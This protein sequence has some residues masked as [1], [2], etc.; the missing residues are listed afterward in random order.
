M[1]GLVRE[2][3]EE[4][5]EEE[6]SGW[7]G[8]WVGGRKYR[9]DLDGETSSQ[10]S[11]FSLFSHLLI[12]CAHMPSACCVG[13][14]EGFSEKIEDLGGWVGGWMGGWVGGWLSL[15]LLSSSS[16][17]SSPVLIARPAG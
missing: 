1:G 13:E 12:P 16:S 9:D 2:E 17:A 14:V 10:R 15:V 7:V 11:Y 6:G 5:E 8:W 4:E 3:E